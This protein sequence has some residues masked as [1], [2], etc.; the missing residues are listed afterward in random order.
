MGSSRF[1][2]LKQNDSF[3]AYPSSKLFN[4]RI[5]SVLYLALKRI[6]VFYQLDLVCERISEFLDFWKSFLK[7]FLEILH[8]A[9]S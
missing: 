7:T 5:K 9:I 3:L 1:H 8:T 6:D 2:E 4:I